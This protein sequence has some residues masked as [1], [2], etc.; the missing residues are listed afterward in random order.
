MGTAPHFDRSTNLK[1]WIPLHHID[2]LCLGFGQLAPGMDGKCALPENQLL[3]E[4][5]H[6]MGMDRVTWYQPTDMRL[7][8]A[9]IFRGHD[10]VH[11]SS[12]QKG[13]ST[14]ERRALWVELELYSDD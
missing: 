6:G 12:V 3:K 7:G 4:C 11:F 9:V 1:L 5:S 14:Q 10:V 13:R 8:D 2:S